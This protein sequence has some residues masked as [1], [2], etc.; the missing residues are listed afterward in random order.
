M[1]CDWYHQPNLDIDT[2][3]GNGLCSMMEFNSF[4]V[5]DASIDEDTLDNSV[6][7]INVL[8]GIDNKWL[9]WPC[10]LWS[11]ACKLIASTVQKEWIMDDC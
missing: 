5:T 4:A 6:L 1:N 2:R 11:L 10:N 3:S 8:D 7:I 9:D